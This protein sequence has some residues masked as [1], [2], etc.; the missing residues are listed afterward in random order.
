MEEAQQKIV[1]FH[2]FSNHFEWFLRA[3]DDYRCINHFRWLEHLPKS[4]L[5][6]DNVDGDLGPGPRMM[7]TTI[8]VDDWMDG[9][10]G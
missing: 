1:N 7:T 4:Q 8:V 10:N 3:R 2:L 9:W 6:I 5:E